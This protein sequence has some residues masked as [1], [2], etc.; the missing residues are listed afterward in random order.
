LVEI[1]SLTSGKCAC[2]PSHV[3]KKQT[4]MPTRTNQ[5]LRIRRP[6]CPIARRLDLFHCL[7]VSAAAAALSAGTCD[8]LERGEELIDLEEEIHYQK[9]LA[10]IWDLVAWNLEGSGP[11][12]VLPT[13]S[14][15]HKRGSEHLSHRRCYGFWRATPCH[16]PARA[17]TKISERPRGIRASRRVEKT[18]SYNAAPADDSASEHGPSP[19]SREATSTPSPGQRRVFFFAKRSRRRRQIDDRCTCPHIA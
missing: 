5:L 9:I 17:H 6:S 16:H 7:N 8:R 10:C 3:Q 12:D 14:H 4:S 19:S 2:L 18:T 13:L 1:D 11:P 15:Y